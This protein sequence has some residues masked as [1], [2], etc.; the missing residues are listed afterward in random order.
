MNRTLRTVVPLLLVAAAAGCERAPDGRRFY[1]LGTG[2]TGG[3]YYPLGGTLASRLTALDTLRTYTAEVTGGS[4]EN[5]KR[6]AAG[7][8]ELGFVI[9]TSA[10][11]AYNGGEDFAEPFTS[12]R[13]VAPL[14][15]NVTHVLV[16]ATSPIEKIEELRGRRVSVGAPG[17]GTEQVARHILEAHGLDYRAIRPQYLSFSESVS[18]LADGAIDA[19]IISAGYPASAVLEGLSTGRARLIPID[20][21]G[22]RILRDRYAYYSPASIPADAYP[23]MTG[24]IPTV[25]VLNWIVARED[26]PDEVV[27]LV[28]DV[29][30]REREQLRETV[31]IAGQINLS[32]LLAAPIPMHDAARGWLRR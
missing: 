21:A 24:A 14:H 9:S 16:G 11:E 8:M 29:L 2:G 32:N 26:L 10:Y 18:A 3:V 4:V 28:L 30:D 17:S 23:G 25:A 1:S 15:P 19:A 27:R 7:E 31:Q 22:Q 12:L 6:I 5:I 13:V 20:T